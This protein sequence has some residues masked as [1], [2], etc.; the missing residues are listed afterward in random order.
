MDALILI[1]NVIQ[2]SIFFVVLYFFLRK[3]FVYRRTSF[4]LKT[5]LSI[6]VLSISALLLIAS[7]LNIAL[8]QMVQ[9]AI[10]SQLVYFLLIIIYI[11]SI[12]SYIESSI[13]LKLIHIIGLAGAKG[14][15]RNELANIYNKEY[16]V[17]RRINRFIEN[18][19]V[20]KQSNCYQRNKNL[21]LFDL[22]SLVIKAFIFMFPS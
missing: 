10:A 6:S 9:I 8:S 3:T 18:K 1:I 5:C 17:M 22:R 13:T 14:L 7:W 21:S 20:I 4:L 16:I 11:L 2:C 12:F 19:I 15:S